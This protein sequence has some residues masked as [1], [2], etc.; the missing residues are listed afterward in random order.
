MVPTG[1]RRLICSERTK[2]MVSIRE[3]V[4]APGLG[5]R[6]AGD[7]GSLDREIEGVHTTDLPRPSRYLLQG[8]LVLTNGLWFPEVEP[9]TWVSDVASA[10]VAAL[11]FGLGSPHPAIPDD[12]VTSCGRHLV[13][14]LE[15]PVH[16]S[17]VTIAD[18]AASAGAGDQRSM[19]R[20]HLERARA[21][22]QAMTE[23]RGPAA[24]LDVVR[25]ATGRDAALVDAAGRVVAATAEAPRPEHAR[26]AV[27][28]GR[29]GRLP[30]EVAPGLTAFGSS[31]GHRALEL[32]LLVAASPLE[33][34]DEG[35]AA[36]NQVTDHLELH[37]ARRRSGRGP[38]RALTLE[39]VERSRDRT[40]GPDEHRSRMWALGLDP[41]QPVLVI[42]A[43][44]EIDEIDAAM[45]ATTSAFVSSGHDGA[46]VILAQALVD[47]DVAGIAAVLEEL[48]SS[49][50]LGVGSTA[51]DAEGLGRSIDDALVA[52]RLARSRPRGDRVIGLG[53]IGSVSAL[54]G[55]IDSEVLRTYRGTLLEPLERWDAERG[56]SLVGTL[57]AFL[58]H[59]CRWRATAA[60]LH[61]HH[62]T[63]RYRLD[64][65]E[66]LTGR[67]LKL[68]A[69]RLD[70][71]IA[72][73]VPC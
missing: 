2:V 63:L 46:T 29:T 21:M 43:D 11:G 51:H 48:G 24:L 28:L 15:V 67:D 68:V 19:L 34:D 12:V 60:A 50:T 10:G 23:G 73:L 13:P 39:L 7:G 18:A 59:G 45:E 47:D 36:V 9:E 66:Q 35:R 20:R 62:N 55:E 53:Q 41:A 40:L 37:T 72:L 44:H 26:T 54:L 61:I 30:A 4:A 56:A 57:R 25:E 65:V 70:L 49:P 1:I 6:I 58:E 5:L 17:F 32:V 16:L 69:D 38:A 42:A 14:L 31:F 52:L 27:S 64:R 8:E 71:Q 22:V 3:L 33:I